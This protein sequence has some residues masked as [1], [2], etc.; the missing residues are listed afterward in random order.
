MIGVVD[1]QTKPE[2][3]LQKIKAHSSSAINQKSN[4]LKAKSRESAEIFVMKD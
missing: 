1:K 4:L 3:E 2:D